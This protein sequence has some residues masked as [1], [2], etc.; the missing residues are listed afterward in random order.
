MNFLA[1]IAICLSSTPAHQCQRATAVHW[2]T[3]S[4]TSLGLST[5]MRDGMFAAARSRLLQGGDYPKVFCRPVDDISR[6]AAR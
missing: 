3:V 5:C 4:E 1:A 2:F 6:Q